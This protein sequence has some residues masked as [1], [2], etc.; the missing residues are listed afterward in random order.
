M[1]CGDENK[2]TFQRKNECEYEFYYKTK[3]GCNSF[4]LKNLRKRMSLYFKHI[5]N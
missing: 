4:Y 3:L 1:E 5:I 2:L